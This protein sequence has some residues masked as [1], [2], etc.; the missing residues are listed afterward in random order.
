M[1]LDRLLAVTLL[2]WLLGRHEGKVTNPSSSSLFSLGI[3]FSSVPFVCT[4]D[5]GLLVWM[6]L[7]YVSAGSYQS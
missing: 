1:M 4:W 6:R 5:M 2:V 7:L 3:G